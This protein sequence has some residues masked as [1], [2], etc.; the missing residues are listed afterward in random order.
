MKLCFKIL[1]CFYVLLSLGFLDASNDSVILDANFHDEVD[2]L[3]SSDG[4][5]TATEEDKDI[6][7]VGYGRVNLTLDDGEL[8]FEVCSNC[9]ATSRVCFETAETGIQTKLKCADISSYCTFEVRHENGKIFFGDAPVYK[10]DFGSP[11]LRPKIHSGAVQVVGIIKFDSCEPKIVDKMIKLYVSIDSS[12]PTTVINAKIHAPP[13]TTT[14]PTK[15]PSPTQS[16]DSAET[17]S[18]PDWGYIILA[19][20][21]L[22]VTGAI[23]GCIAF[24]VY[25]KRQSSKRA[26]QKPDET[27]P[28]ATISKADVAAE[29]PTKKNDDL[30]SAKAEQTQI[31]KKE[32]KTK[33]QAP[34]TTEDAP[35]QKPKKQKKSKTPEPT[36]AEEVPAP[37]PSKQLPP[38]NPAAC[39]PLVKRLIPR[40]MKSAKTDSLDETLKKDKT[41]MVES[42]VVS[43]GKHCLKADESDILRKM[44]AD[45]PTNVQHDVMP[46]EVNLL[47]FPVSKMYEKMDTM[48]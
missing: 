41:A 34:T 38:P 25:K 27:I 37:T 29:T 8:I 48:A 42:L 33:T 17:S 43:T 21:A 9:V 40:G 24:Y 13:T 46:S 28:K 16:P 45:Y 32:K 15:V 22:I 20:A 12:C 10:E 23:I 19:I 6:R 44:E 7:L 35:I 31:P 47:C 4:S 14:S 2:G 39:Y 30:E 18:F 36:T 5:V 1:F 11:C 26:S 3:L